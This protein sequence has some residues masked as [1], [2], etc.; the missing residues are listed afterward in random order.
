MDNDTLDS[1]NQ[2][3]CAAIAAL[4]RL[5]R[6]APAA[7]ED[8]VGRRYPRCRRRVLVSHDA[9][10]NIERGPGMA[11]RQRA[12]FGQGFGHLHS[13]LQAGPTPRRGN[14]VAHRTSMPDNTSDARLQIG[15]DA[16]TAD[17]NQRRNQM[18][19]KGSINR[20]MNRTE[21]LPVLLLAVF[22]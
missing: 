11:S 18:A 21:W 8:G 5:G 20:S 12:D 1:M 6:L 2:F 22:W 9:D 3:K 7:I 4:D 17:V 13:R 14:R 15:L 10:E 19:D 16:R